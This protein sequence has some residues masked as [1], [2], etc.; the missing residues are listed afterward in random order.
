MLNSET[1]PTTPAILTSEELSQ[2]K[3]LLFTIQWFNEEMASDP[4]NEVISAL[5]ESTNHGN[6]NQI[7]EA[8]QLLYKLALNSAF[9][10]KLH[11]KL[12]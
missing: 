11:S 7:G 6:S 4:A 3:D 8:V 12:K 5:L 2:L 1:M 9:V 10:S